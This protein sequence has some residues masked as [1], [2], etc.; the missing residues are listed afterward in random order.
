LRADAT[1]RRRSTVR[2]AIMGSGAIGGYYGARAQEA[3]HDVTFIARGAH[4]AAMRRAG[5]KIE[6][7]FGDITLPSVVATEDPAEA[8]PA[9]LVVFAVKMYDTEGAG[10]AMAPLVGPATRIVTLQNGV[11]SAGLLARAH[12]GAT[13]VSGATYLSSVVAEPGVIANPGGQ[14]RLVLGGA[15][16][17]VV[18]GFGE[19]IT[20]RPGVDLVLVEDPG[21]EIWEKFVTVAAFSGATTLM[22]SGCGPILEHEETRRFLL[23]LR[24]EALAICEAAGP[25][26]EPGAADRVLARWESLPPQ[27]RAS[28]THDLA[29]GRRLELEWL[30]GA[31]HRLGLKSGIPTPAHSAVYRGLY[32]H[33]NG[34]PAGDQR[35]V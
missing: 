34:T 10:A 29:R 23:Q 33:R 31:V 14:K 9:D 20:S 19:A 3:G 35:A 18:R 7:A 8:G 26:L 21:P 25:Q 4:L 17:R 11:E 16:D 1:N 13:V 6:S 32:L 12:P 5:L 15:S 28:M 22:R 30:S 24:D 2:I 27:T